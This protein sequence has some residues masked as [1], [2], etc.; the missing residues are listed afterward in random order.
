M[1]FGER[2]DEVDGSEHDLPLHKAKGADFDRGSANGNYRSENTFTT[3]P[4][5]WVGTCSNHAKGWIKVQQGFSRGGEWER[6]PN[7]TLLGSHY[8]RQRLPD[9]GVTPEC[10]SV[11]VGDVW[12]GSIQTMEWMQISMR[13]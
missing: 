5:G 8:Y 13:E 11:R 12:V 9:S 4:P 6:V 2:P 10:F 3:A 1:V 7:E